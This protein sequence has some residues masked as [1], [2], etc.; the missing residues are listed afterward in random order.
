[1]KK[2][3][4]QNGTIIDAAETFNTMQNNT[5]EAINAVDTK[6]NNNKKDI[7][8]LTKIAIDTTIDNHEEEVVLIKSDNLVYDG[9]WEQGSFNFLTGELQT[10]TNRIRTKTKIKISP[11]TTY[12]I[13]CK[14]P[15]GE[16]AVCYYTKDG[17]VVAGTNE[18]TTNTYSIFTTPSD[19]YYCIIR[20]GNNTNVISSAS[21][22]NIQLKK[23]STTTPYKPYKSNEIYANKEKYTDT[24]NIGV[25]PNNSG[26]WVEHSKNLFDKDSNII[27]G[28][29]LNT[30]GTTFDSSVSSIKQYIEIQPNTTY[31]Y[32]GFSDSSYTKRICFYSSNTE[33]SFISSVEATTDYKTFTTPSNAKYLRIQFK[34]SELNKVMLNEGNYIPPSIKVN[35]NGVYETIYQEPVVLWNNPSP[36]NEFAGQSITLNDDLNNY[37]YYEVI[38]KWSTSNG[39]SFTTGRI[40][41]NQ[42]SLLQLSISTNYVRFIYVNGTRM[43]FENSVQYSTYGSNTTTNSN[44]TLIPYQVLGYK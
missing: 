23:G 35:N 1:M 34:T 5:E 39:R 7:D 43:T 30:N 3:N 15:L 40:P 33:S 42:G 13:S 44:T 10:S 11:N 31:T 16:F 28:K 22:Q 26:L 32:S 38:G 14:L 20:I 2:I 19:A 24:L 8:N 9:M 29:G 27:S 12:T 37:K 4:F 25:E 36:N 6:A 21:G 41:F 18:N 17:V